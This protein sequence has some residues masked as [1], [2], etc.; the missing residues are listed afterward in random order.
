LFYILISFAVSTKK[1]PK[2]VRPQMPKNVRPQMAKNVR[3]QMAQ[4]AQMAF[5]TQM[6]LTTTV[7]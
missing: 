4:M 6:A 5:C 7:R 2:N 1:M 3:P